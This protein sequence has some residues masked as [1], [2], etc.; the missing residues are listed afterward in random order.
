MAS[1]VAERARGRLHKAV[2]R[3]VGIEC[4]SSN[5]LSYQLYFTEVDSPSTSNPRYITFLNKYV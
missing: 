2:V 5:F 3:I 4:P 1:S